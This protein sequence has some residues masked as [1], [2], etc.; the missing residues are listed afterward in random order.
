MNE[1]SEHLNESDV[2]HDD[3]EDESDIT[4]L[5]KT[6]VPLLISLAMFSFILNVFILISIL[7]SKYLIR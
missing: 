6:I 4:H 5:Y 7:R 3:Y 1:S 2:Y